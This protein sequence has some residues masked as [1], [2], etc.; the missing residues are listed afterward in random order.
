MGFKQK[1]IIST[2][3]SSTNTLGFANIFPLISNLWYTDQH[4]VF[5][6]IPTKDSNEAFNSLEDVPAPSSM[7]NSEFREMVDQD[8][9]VQILSKLWHF[10]L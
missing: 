6:I 7:S 5:H 2:Y 8:G 3:V 4:R 9:Q 1:Y 10:E